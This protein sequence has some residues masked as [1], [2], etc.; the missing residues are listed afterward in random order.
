MLLLGFNTRL[1]QYLWVKMAQAIEKLL[2]YTLNLIWFSVK[3]MTDMPN[4][5]N[6]HPE[7]NNV[8]NEAAP[9]G[10]KPVS[11]STL[12]DEPKEQF[13]VGSVLL[14]FTELQSDV[15]TVLGTSP[16][17]FTNLL[18]TVKAFVSSLQMK[19]WDS[20]RGWITF[21]KLHKCEVVCGTPKFRLCASCHEP[22]FFVDEELPK[23][24]QRC[25][26]K[27]YQG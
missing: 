27:V 5:P 8:N 16:T 20:E 26:Y 3:S 6:Y 11:S 17:L 10:P 4:H 25:A 21:P 13:R 1:K 14:T 19:S 7:L 23:G 12:V 9:G 2:G 22:S 15:R 18:V 24:S